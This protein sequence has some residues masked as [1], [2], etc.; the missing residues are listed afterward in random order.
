MNQSALSVNELNA[1][2][3]IIIFPNPSSGL[4]NIKIN[5]PSPTDIEIYDV[6]GRVIL[7]DTFFGNIWNTQLNE[8][9]GIYLMRIRTDKKVFTSKITLK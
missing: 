9:S 5:S 4:I 8:G 7:S 6:T 2:L 3:D 1:D